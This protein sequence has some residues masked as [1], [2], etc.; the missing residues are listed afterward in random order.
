MWDVGMGYYASCLAG[1]ASY[2]DCLYFST[3]TAIKYYDTVSGK[4]STFQNQSGTCGIYIHN[5]TLYYCKPDG[6]GSFE[7]AGEFVLGDT[8]IGQPHF[9]NGQIVTRI[10]TDSDEEIFVFFANSNHLECSPVNH[11]GISKLTFDSSEETDVFFWSKNLK[12]LKP[13]IKV[14]D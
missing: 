5:N 6:N 1:L 14:S 10:Y 12:P 2:G 8:I 11:K 4:V 9:E 13:K 3:D 7:Y